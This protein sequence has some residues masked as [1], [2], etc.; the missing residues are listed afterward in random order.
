MYP[1]QLT[2]FKFYSWKKIRK[3]NWSI[4]EYL[5]I[6]VTGCEL[7]GCPSSSN[8]IA[9]KNKMNV[10]AMNTVFLFD[11]IQLLQCYMMW[12]IKIQ[13]KSSHA[14]IPLFIFFS[15]LLIDS[16][17]NVFNWYLT[18]LYIRCNPPKNE[19]TT[20]FLFPIKCSF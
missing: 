4:Q 19:P 7:M 14:W 1:W 18:N 13:F 6:L 16:H 10:E 20:P 5:V 11:R 3:K 12:N 15:L 2:D 17:A 9:W 8:I